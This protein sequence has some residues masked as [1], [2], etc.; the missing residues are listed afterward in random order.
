MIKM[1]LALVAIGLV[2]LLIPIR[3]HRLFKMG[4]IPVFGLLVFGLYHLWGNN[5]LLLEK[6]A[7]DKITTTLVEINNQPNLTSSEI[8]ARLAKLETQVNSYAYALAQLASIYNQ[9]GLFDKSI[10]LLDRAI[11]LKPKEIEFKVLWVYSHSLKEKGKLESGVRELADKLIK[12]EP[13]DK[14]LLNLLAIDDYMSGHYPAAIKNWQTLLKLDADLSQEQRL[15]I[16][17]AIE[18]ANLQV[19][20]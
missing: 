17:R 10:G 1:G 20:R 19:L 16:E 15:P 12:T 3:G 13:N 7:L 11:S 14:I 2:M 9:I 8:E 18:K 5:S 6:E 4:F